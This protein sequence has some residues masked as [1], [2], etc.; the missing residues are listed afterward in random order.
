MFFR[1]EAVSLKSRLRNAKAKISRGGNKTIRSRIPANI[2][3]ENPAYFLSSD[4]FKMF[5]HYKL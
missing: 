5:C 3:I 2:L 4:I 1:R